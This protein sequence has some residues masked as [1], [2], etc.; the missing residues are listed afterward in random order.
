MRGVRPPISRVLLLPLLLA[1]CNQS[2]F[3]NS[4]PRGRDADGGITG[5]A[6]PCLGDAVAEWNGEQ[7]G[8]HARF[9][10]RDYGRKPGHDAADMIPSDVVGEYTFLGRGTPAPAIGTCADVGG[11]EC[12]GL[13]DVLLLAP[14]QLDADGFD[15][16]VQLK[17]SVSGTLRVY[18]TFATK[19]GS[20][21]GRQRL[22][23]GRNARA[24][25][26][27]DGSYR[28]GEATAVF[29]L[30]VDALLGDRLAL[31][32]APPL[33]GTAV[34]VGVTFFASELASAPQRCQLGVRFDDGPED[35]CHAMPL[36][37]LS[38]NTPAVLSSTVTSFAPDFGS[39]EHFVSG[40]YLKSATPPDY[41]G[42][43]TIQFWMKVAEPPEFQ[44][45][46]YADWGCLEQGG[47]NLAADDDGKFYVGG[48]WKDMNVDY[49]AQGGPPAPVFM[50]GARPTDGAWHFY[51]VTRS[52]AD[53][54]IRLC[55][56]GAL[57]AQTEVPAEKDM[58]SGIG[59]TIGRNVDYSPAYFA[60]DVDDLRILKR[61]LPCQ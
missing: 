40:S 31:L 32:S 39:A 14:G 35:L 48:Y 4:G 37:R 61:A 42:D 34:P 11:D 15:P 22:L 57:R 18:G 44:S 8:T 26:L 60:G 50:A 36:E 46:V 49:C 17:A 2:L 52:T 9:R 3:D 43:F 47:L 59:P 29:D 45:C 19:T 53:A 7:G 24:D 5:C 12:A 30:E 20:A 28:P 25:L 21:G 56:D 54:K 23:L 27:F 33:D 58:T 41:S 38:T 6:E 10:Y 16:A 13:G 51:R 55:I 1:G